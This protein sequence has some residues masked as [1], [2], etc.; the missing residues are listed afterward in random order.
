[1]D[2]KYIPVLEEFHKFKNQN[3]LD[4]YRN[5]EY[6]KKK[7]D[8]KQ[9]DVSIQSNNQFQ[10][11]LRD[12]YNGKMSKLF[13]LG[14]LLSK[15]VPKIDSVKELNK[16]FTK[17]FNEKIPDK[18]VYKLLRVIILKGFDIKKG[19]KIKYKKTGGSSSVLNVSNEGVLD[20]VNTELNEKSK[21][22]LNKITKFRL[23]S[24][25]ELQAISIYNHIIE[26]IKL[27]PKDYQILDYGCGSCKKV[28]ELGKFLKLN[29]N[30]IHGCDIESWSNYGGDRNGN[31]FIFTQITENE[32]LP[33]EN[34]QF[35]LVTST[36]VLHHI[37]NLDFALKELHRIISKGGYLYIEEHTAYDN[38]DKLICDIEHAL[39]ECVRRDE[40]ERFYKDF[41]SKYYD[42]LEWNYILNNYGFELVKIGNY[43][44][45]WNIEKTTP[46]LKFYAI[47]K[48]K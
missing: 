36:M 38:Y 42:Y 31:K 1:M 25:E 20:F 7:K 11:L 15:F 2:N 16:L 32:K 4:M 6:L 40:S 30:R 35:G 23:I 41:Y 33:F 26:F 27:F 5:K 14:R 22:L 48:K 17:I 45:N 28:G 18:D 37:K 39:Y 9:F 24:H 47:F 19:K 46:T 21:R 3:Q 10:Y 13:R 29:K 43:R 8:E 44:Y 34:E 12:K